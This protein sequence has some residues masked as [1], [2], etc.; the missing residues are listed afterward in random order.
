MNLRAAIAGRRGRATDPTRVT[1]TGGA[2][3][4][5][6]GTMG[7]HPLRVAVLSDAA[8]DRNGVGSY[9]ADLVSELAT[10]IDAARLFCPEDGH[11]GWHRYLTAPLPGDGTQ[12]IWLPRPR[13]LWR[14]VSGFAPDAIVVPTPGPYGIA[15]LVVASRLRVPLIVG[16]HTHYEALA[17]LYWERGFG[18]LCQTYLRWCNELLFRHSAVVLAN[19]RDMIEQ[20]RRQGAVHVELMGTSVARHYLELPPVALDAHVRRILFAGRLAGEKNIPEI[21]EVARRRP[22]LSITIVGDGPLKPEVDAAARE[23]PNLS[24]PGWIAREALTDFM[25]AH[26]L[27]LLPSHVESFGTVALEGLARARP[28][29]VSRACGIADWPELAGGLFT[30]GARET[31]LD[32]VDRVLAL[33]LAVRQATA[34]R[35]REAARALNDWNVTSWIERIEQ[36][37]MRGARAA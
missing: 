7:R 13:R 1:P 4:P 23:L 31:P 12:R 5:G 6:V 27:L 33:P 17:G 37:R 9:Y 26:D 18:R 22:N 29:I 15:G 21:I 32:A 8:P 28:V 24:A 34:E 11:S 3:A 16:F 25:D 20:A 19:S 10:R 36:H 2:G 14:D 30:V 35:G